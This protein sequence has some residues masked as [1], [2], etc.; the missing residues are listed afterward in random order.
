[1]TDQ[2]KEKLKQTCV[3]FSLKALVMGYILKS[4]GKISF[5]LWEDIQH[6]W[7]PNMG[8]FYTK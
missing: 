1:M 5:T 4:S 2:K 6:S 8:K 7:Q 3:I